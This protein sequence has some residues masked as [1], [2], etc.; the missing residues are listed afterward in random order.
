MALVRTDRGGLAAP[1]SA[2]IFEGRVAR[3]HTPADPLYY[4]PGKNE[5]RDQSEVERIVK[6]LPGLKFTNLHPEGFL[7]D[8]VEADVIGVVL[9]ARVDGDHAVATILVYDGGLE[10]I[11]DGLHELS[12]GYA[13]RTDAEG[14]QRDIDPDHVALVP[15]A[16]CGPS[17]ALRVDCV[18]APVAASACQCKNHAVISE[19]L[20]ADSSPNT[21]A[22][23]AKELVMEELQKQLAAALADV[24]AHTAR[25]DQAEKDLAAAT[26]RADVA[27]T[28][29]Q[30]AADNAKADL[31]KAEALTATEKLRA[32]EA[33]ASVAAEKLRADAAE[34]DAV[35]AQV[36]ARVEVLT[37]AKT[38]GLE[39]DN[40]DAMSNR[41]I[42]AAI[43]KHVDGN[44]ID[45]KA[46]PAY[47]DG[48]F[49]GALTR[50][51]KAVASR[52]EVLTTIEESRQVADAAAGI[53]SQ[54]AE[55]AAR[56][57]SAERRKSAFSRKKTQE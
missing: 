4:G 54:K 16:R 10:A 44:E 25:A 37:A 17:C 19:L 24:A 27:A 33:V 38:V 46:V 43:V 41:D 40:L 47:V 18:S 5:Y 7:R 9:S 32:D 12:L 57:A 28:A 21:P 53:D 14:Y 45:A 2:K 6:A 20:M 42:K 36:K 31:A 15:T 48:M 55:E 29:A 52:V 26:V 11:Q 56:A 34:S 30:I 35:S 49:A 22:A 13:C 51:D 39:V 50:F 3:T 1:V 8:G 23:A